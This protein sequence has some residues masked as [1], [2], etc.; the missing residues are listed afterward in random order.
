MVGKRIKSDL[1]YYLDIVERTKYVFRQAIVGPGI[2]DSQIQ[3]IPLQTNIRRGLPDKCNFKK[4]NLA[5]S[6]IYLPFLMR[7]PTCALSKLEMRSLHSLQVFE[8]SS[9]C[10]ECPPPLFGANVTSG[11]QEK[12]LGLILNVDEKISRNK[13]RWD[14]IWT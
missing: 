10:W 11:T 13:I 1:D 14:L 7:L 3:I 5:P 9:H 12:V 4:C 2:S 8:H 6:S